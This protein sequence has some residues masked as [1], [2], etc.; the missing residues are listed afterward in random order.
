M[1]PAR[2]KPA[3]SDLVTTTSSPSV[4][5]RTLS[6]PFDIIGDVHGCCQELHALLYKLGY[7]VPDDPNHMSPDLVRAPEGR[8]VVFVGDFVDRGPNSMGALKTAMGLIRSGHAL[9]VLGNHDDKFWRWLN[10][11]KVQVQHGLSGTIAEFERE[12]PEMRARLLNFFAA[13]PLHLWLDGGKLAVAH[14]GILD[15]LLGQT[16]GRVRR[17]CRYGDTEGGRDQMG[18]PIRYHWAAHY[19]GKT[20]IVYG[21]TPLERADWVNETLCIDTGCCF[22]GSLTALRWPEREIVSVKALGDYAPRLRPFGHPPTRP[23]LA[24]RT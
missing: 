4:D 6:G 22:G 15:D 23:Q 21:H 20:A 9:A 14:A 1:A 12:P 5:Q 8:R 7:D 11:N 2:H 10:G 17:F 24:P 18:L 13:L 19:R 16:G 3:P